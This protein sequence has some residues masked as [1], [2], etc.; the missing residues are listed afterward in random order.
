MKIEVNACGVGSLA[1]FI[2]GHKQTHLNRVLGCVL[3]FQGIYLS[4]FF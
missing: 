2:T 1:R 3:C 4:G